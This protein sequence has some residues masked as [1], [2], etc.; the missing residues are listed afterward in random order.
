MNR[1]DFLR[2]VTVAGASQIIGFREEAE[3]TAKVN[4]DKTKSVTLS[5]DHFRL[6]IMA[7]TGLQCHLLHK[8]SNTL[9]ADEMYSYAFGVP[10]FSSVS[11]GKSVAKFSGM[12]KEGIQVEHRFKIDPVLP[13]IEEEITVRNTKSQ[14]VRLP[15]RC[16]FVLP[17]RPD[18]L[19]GF[20]F[21]ALPY[22]REPRGSHDQYA[23]YSLDEILFRPRRSKLREDPPRSQA[24]WPRL[25]EDYASE[26]WAFTNGTHGFLATKHNETAR[27]WAILDRVPLEGDLIGLRWGGAGV[28]AGDPEGFCELAAG[29]T[30]DFGTTRLTA[31]EGDV[32]QGFYAFRDEMESRGHGVPAGFDPPVHWNE[33]YDNKLWWVGDPAYL[34][35]A[36]R[37]KY[38]RLDDL[39][40]EAAK[41]KAIGCEALYCDPGWDTPQSSKIWDENRLGK[42]TDFVA[43]LKSDYGLRLSLHTPLTNWV[44]PNCDVIAGTDRL[45]PDRKVIPYS[46]CGAS[47]QYLEE[48]SRRLQALAR[49]GVAFF[50]FD[51]TWFNGECWDPKHGHS[52]P[53][54]MSEHV[55]ATNRLAR[56]VH[57]QCPDV[58][59]EM[60][61]QAVGGAD[62]RYVPTYYGHGIDGSGGKGFDSVWAFELMWSPMNDLLA[63]RSIALY[64]YNLAYSLPLYIHID[65]RTDNA[66]ALVFWWNASTCRHLGFGGTP[67]DAAVRSAHA[68]AMKTYRRLKPFFAAGTFYGIDEL[69]HIHRH[70]QQNA[71]V[72]NC[73]NLNPDPVVRKIAFEPERFG[74]KPGRHYQFSGADFSA[75][76]P[77]TANVTIPGR[78]HV[79]LEVTEAS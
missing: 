19:K 58:L 41:A 63:G 40:Q 15:F 11:A 21:S 20:V 33:L 7:G 39:K 49:S 44:G 54:T 74:L 61:D 55:D 12:T 47:K 52:V 59:I 62:I 27:E 13:W 45:G 8:A 51:G 32:L 17:V 26:G 2:L 10:M 3:A 79:F 30:H 66:Q 43:L 60:H 53:S 77:Y 36:N 22:R 24:V 4:P 71:A 78:G 48:T 35:P 57:D 29:A 34:E 76:N 73:F 68:S 16:G 70:P 56:M 75:G 5:N 38:Y 64:Y 50:M 65:L 46:P 31:F 69:T 72:V 1:K 42:L 6:S 67:T 14:L 9:L 37:E 28:S 23:D 18:S 25:Y